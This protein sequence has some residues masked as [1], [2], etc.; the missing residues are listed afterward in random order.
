MKILFYGWGMDQSLASF[1]TVCRHYAE[2][3]ELAEMEISYVNIL[4]LDENMDYRRE[5]GNECDL[6]A[7]VPSDFDYFCRHG[8]L[9]DLTPFI[10]ESFNRLFIDGLEELVTYDGKHMAIPTFTGVMGII[11]NKDWFRKAGIPF[12]APGWSWD[13]FMEAALR[14]R[15]LCKEPE[16]YPVQI[17]FTLDILESV[18]LSKGGRYVSADGK[19]VSG[20]MDSPE[21]AAAIDWVHR[22]ISE[23]LLSP[24]S[25]SV[26]RESF[27]QGNIGMMVT[28]LYDIPQHQL[29]QAGVIGMPVIRGGNPA[30]LPLPKMIGVSSASQDPER[31]YRLLEYLTCTENEFTGQQIDGQVYSLKHAAAPSENPVKA[32][33]REELRYAKAGTYLK[34]ADWYGGLYDRELERILEGK[35]AREALQALAATVALRYIIQ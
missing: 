23:E 4:D 10:G 7:M 22:L 12:P 5:I 9:A 27:E 35:P 11:Y 6:I 2:T 26:L 14:F 33:I 3:R 25:Q 18:V 29:D 1:E 32:F 21:T 28:W 19:S 17:A 20:Y 16:Q 8:Y 34:I 13:D 15:S 24:Y 31:A 30:A